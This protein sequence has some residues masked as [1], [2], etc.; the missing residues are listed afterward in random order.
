[1]ELKRIRELAL[2]GVPEAQFLLAVLIE[3]GLVAD[4][5]AGEMVAWY[6]RSAARGYAPAMHE[7]ADKYARGNGV[8]QDKVRAF[9]LQLAAAK[10]GYLPAYSE[11]AAC[12]EFAFGTETNAEEAF[13]WTLRAAELGDRTSM[14]YLALMLREGRGVVRDPEHGLRWLKR[15]AELGDA[16]SAYQLAIEHLASNEYV[17]AVRWLKAAADGG[18]WSAHRDLADIYRTGKGDVEPDRHLERHHRE[19]AARLFELQ[20]G[21]HDSSD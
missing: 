8:E 17:E 20:I 4:V 6:S 14:A 9:D 13:N 21:E 3:H 10:S 15:A 5:G 16:D 1:M 18:V 19:E 12:Y 2:G 7:L 11:L